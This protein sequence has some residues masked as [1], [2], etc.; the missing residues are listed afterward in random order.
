VI[1]VDVSARGAVPAKER[2]RAHDRLAQLDRRIPDPVLGARV[3]LTQEANPRL[4]RP[5]RAEAELDVNGRL[6]CGRVAAATMPQAIGELGEQL[7]RQLDEFEQ[8]RTR[9]HRRP[10]HPEDG[11]WRHGD[12]SPP[13][14]AYFPRPIEERELI[15]RKTFAIDPVDPVEAVA[16]MLDLD[17]AFYL[18]RDA[19]TGEDAVVYRRD[20]GRIGLIAQGNAAGHGDEG[21]VREP[22]RFSDPIALQTAIAEMNELSHRFM[23]FVDDSSRR[24]T[25]IYMRYDGHYGL[26]E[27]AA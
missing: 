3:M 5:A 21:P 15:R 27:P 4:E 23:F 9:L 16:Q 7:E 12:W 2:R 17:H 26:L 14:P 1:D 13:R 20:D 18:F 10:E 11:E 22:S 24:G 19:Q 8:R 25:V 6:V